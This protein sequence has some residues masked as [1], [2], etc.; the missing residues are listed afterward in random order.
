MHEFME[1]DPIP[2][3]RIELIKCEIKNELEEAVSFRNPLLRKKTT[4]PA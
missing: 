4:M 2:P 1:K 3:E